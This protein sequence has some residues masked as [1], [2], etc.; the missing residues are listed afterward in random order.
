MLP[1]L[2][3]A[4]RPWLI[5][6]VARRAEVDEAVRAKEEKIAGR[7][8]PLQV[9]PQRGASPL[10]LLHQGERRRIEWDGADRFS[11]R[12]RPDSGGRVEDLFAILDDNPGLV[13]PGVLA[14]PA[15]QD[16]VFGTALQLLGPGELA[17]MAQSS[18]VH[19][20]LEIPAAD[21]VLRPHV[22][23][24]AGHQLEKL[25]E[26]GLSLANLYADRQEL[27]RLLAAR[28]GSD[29]VAPVRREIDRLLGALHGPA[30]AAERNLE[31]PL[32]KTREQV[33]K[34]LDTFADKAV[35]AAA[36]RNE[37][38]SRRAHQLREICLP[39]GRPQERVVS[40]AHFYGKYGE[41][42][43]RAF[44]E[45]M[46]LDPTFFEVVRLG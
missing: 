1:E 41:A 19:S 45:Q 11:L 12:G 23:V 10:F 16:A 30:L 39:F 20:V 13:S 43:T 37:V 24:L 35:A 40:A 7:G 31:R 5:Q 28:D 8:F 32:E 22:V 25:A 17:Y 6:L 44:W 34:A 15:V 42:L 9:A 26:S 3:A 27:E 29:F 33:L 46:R 18:A 38:A 4:E 14:R 36:R 2:K 21:V